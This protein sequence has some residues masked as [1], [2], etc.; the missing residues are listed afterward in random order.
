MAARGWLFFMLLMFCFSLGHGKK[1]VTKEVKNYSFKL[2][3]KITLLRTG[4]LLE[5]HILLSMLI[6]QENR[7]FICQEC[8][9][10]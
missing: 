8:A 6:D 7:L 9:A 3:F 4:I 1:K 10:E 5:P 2:F